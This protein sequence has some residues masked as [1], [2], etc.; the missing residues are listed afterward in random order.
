MT[1]PDLSAL[2][3][4]V[5]KYEQKLFS[6][7]FNEF[8]AISD[9]TFFQGI[10]K[11]VN[12]TKLRA[13]DGARP[14]SAQLQSSGT[15][16]KYT[17]TVLAPVWGKR[18]ITVIPSDYNETWMAEVKSAGVNPKEI[19][20]ASY[21]WGQ[22]MIELAAEL[23]D[24]TIYFGFDKADAVAYNIANAYVVGNY[25]TFDTPSTG[26]NDYYKCIANAAAGD[27]PATDPLKWQM[28]NAEAICIGFGKRIADAV[29][30]GDLTPIATGAITS[31]DAYA[32]FIEMF[33]SLPVAYQK[34][35]ASI[36]GSFDSC[37]A[38]ADDFETKVGKYTERDEKTGEVFL[39]KTNRMCKIVPAT[40]MGDSGRLIATPKANVIIGTDSA[41]DFNKMETDVHLRAIDA[42]IDFSLG[43]IFRDFEA[44]RVSDVA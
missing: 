17:G 35:G 38:L 42:G 7:L 9:L 1:S 32:Q 3:A 39:S 41:S 5:G 40:W 26:L 13:G 18:D 8:D 4:Y 21:V 14:G 6:K 34:R 33:R 31:S 22:V 43:T 16:L 29:T 27:T 30:A 24:K 36:F 11:A 12:M 2:A 25:V 28:V 20:F 19:P 23:N 37:N 15:D 10:K 44:M